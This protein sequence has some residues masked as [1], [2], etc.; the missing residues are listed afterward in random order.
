MKILS[1]LEFWKWMKYIVYGELQWIQEIVLWEESIPKKELKGK[2]YI[3]TTQ[4]DSMIMEPTFWYKMITPK[5][6]TKGSR[7][8][9]HKHEDHC[10]DNQDEHWDMVSM[11]PTLPVVPGKVQRQWTLS[12]VLAWLL[13]SIVNRGLMNKVESI[14][15]DNCY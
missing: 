7:T 2:R 1:N 14:Q 4:N 12:K 6:S 3:P 11:A 9:V 5:E 15:S 10:L 8:M 13:I